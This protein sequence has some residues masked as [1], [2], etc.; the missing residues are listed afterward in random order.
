VVPL[1]DAAQRQLLNVASL[2]FICEWVAA[3]S[4]VYWGVGAK[5]DRS[6]SIYLLFR[7]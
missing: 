6:E 7:N 4:D 5:Q 3:V 1:E 2:P